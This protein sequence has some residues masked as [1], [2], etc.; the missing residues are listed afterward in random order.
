[1]KKILLLAIVL[2]SFASIGQ[3]EAVP[4]KTNQ[5]KIFIYWGW[6]RA[7][8]TDSDIHFEGN[9]YDF[10][11]DKV[12]AKDRPTRFALD[13]YFHPIR[14]TIPQTMFKAG[15][16][17]KEK[18]NVSFGVDHMKYVMP[19]GQNVTINGTIDVDKDSTYN[20]IYSNETIELTHDFLKFEHTDGLNYVNV[21]VNRYDKLLSFFEDKFPIDLSIYEGVGIGVLIPKTNA[22]LMNFEQ[23]DDF[24]L[25]GFGLNAKVGLDLTFFN[26]FFVRH[27]AKVGYINMPDIRTTPEKG[28][29]ASQQFGF[30]ERTLLIGGSFKIGKKG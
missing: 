25:A 6:N 18:Y 7:N 1:M 14:I 29:K 28:D 2:T 8:Y 11:L 19:Q 21:E 23:H 15:F 12:S 3:E 20:G 30:F 17:F 13:P 27:E 9:G 16:F 4:A 22:K 10:T 5:G 24:H 26:H